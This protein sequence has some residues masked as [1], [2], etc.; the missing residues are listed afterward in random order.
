MLHAD[1]VRY[2]HHG[3]VR[4]RVHE[5]SGQ[6][7]LGRHVLDGHVLS[8]FYLL[9]CKCAMPY[10]LCSAFH[11]DLCL[12]KYVYSLE[13]LCTGYVRH[14]PGCMLIRVHA[15]SGQSMCMGKDVFRGNVL[16]TSY[17]WRRDY[18]V[19]DRIHAPVHQKLHL[20][21]FV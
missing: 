7:M 19:P 11:Q 13:L 4:S 14:S 3:H 15:L 10:G 2:R 9:D 16:L 5:G 20:W 6:G 12:G 17:L 18:S 21:D 1:P 8:T